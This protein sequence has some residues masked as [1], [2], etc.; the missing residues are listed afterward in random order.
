MKIV[1]GRIRR[2]YDEALN[3][4]ILSTNMLLMALSALNNEIHYND[5]LTDKKVA[6]YQSYRTI[7]AKTALNNGVDKQRISKVMKFL[8]SDRYPSY[9][10]ILRLI[11]L[12]NSNTYIYHADYIPDTD[13]VFKSET[14]ISE[15]EQQPIIIRNQN[16]IEQ[17]Q[18]FSEICDTLSNS[19][20]IS[21]ITADMQAKIRQIQASNDIIMQALK[22]H[23]ND[24]NK[25]LCDKQF[26]NSYDKFSYLIGIIKKK[27]PE[28]IKKLERDKKEEQELFDDNAKAI[29]DGDA[30][31]EEM[32]KILCDK[33]PNSSHYGMHDYVKEELTKA[34]ERVKKSKEQY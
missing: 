24:I 4:N 8:S 18:Q 28:V 14:E 10:Q 13:L 12:I 9:N 23:K 33:Y 34:I 31:L 25:A 11:T 1:T 32:I 22:W 26:N 2:L 30:T 16:N 17:E 15:Q 21:P 19:F 3:H 7:L 5:N 29:I 20:Y 6:E 27:I